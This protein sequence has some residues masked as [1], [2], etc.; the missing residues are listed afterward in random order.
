MDNSKTL[1]VAF[2]EQTMQSTQ[3]CEGLLC[4]KVVSPLQKIPNTWDIQQ[5]K[6]MLE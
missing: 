2:V 4:S 1:E 5:T 6:R 3:G